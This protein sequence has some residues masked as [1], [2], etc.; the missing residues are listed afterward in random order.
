MNTRPP[1]KSINLQWIIVNQFD[2][3][4]IMNNYFLMNETLA[5]LNS[6]KTIEKGYTPTYHFYQLG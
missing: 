6:I 1:D 4:T 2:Y 5:S 3:I